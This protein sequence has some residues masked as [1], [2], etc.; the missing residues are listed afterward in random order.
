MPQQLQG[1]SK[2]RFAATMPAP[3]SLAQ[4]CEKCRFAYTA[5]RAGRDQVARQTLRE[6][7]DLV[8][9]AGVELDG[10][11]KRALSPRAEFLA[12]MSHELR[13]P[14]NVVLGYAEMAREATDLEESRAHVARIEGAARHLLDVVH[15]LLCVGPIAPG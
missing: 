13:T 1:I 8:Q 7:V 11:D 10:R 2:V 3:P 4:L 12:V 14:L 15:Q 5:Q 9:H 6:I